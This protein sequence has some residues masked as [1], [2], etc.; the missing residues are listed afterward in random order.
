M[1]MYPAL[2]LACICSKW[3]RCS[4]LDMYCLFFVA[5]H[6]GSA[7]VWSGRL[8][9][10]YLHVVHNSMSSWQ[11]HCESSL[12]SFDEC[13]LSARWLTS[14]KPSQPAWAVSPP[15]GCYR[16]HPPYHSLSLL[17]PEGETHFTIRRRVEGWIDLRTAV[18][19]PVQDA[20]EKTVEIFNPVGSTLWC[21]T[22]W[23]QVSCG[24][25]K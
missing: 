13:T 25:V 23:L 10:I 12:S 20:A 18:R 11:G 15:V 5:H 8:I 14:L 17:N 7:R 2:V 16:P 4:A 21:C 9:Q 3:D 24:K 22:W 19:V 6:L 1:T